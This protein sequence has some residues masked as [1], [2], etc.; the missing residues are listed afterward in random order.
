MNEVS[1]PHD[2]ILGL[3]QYSYVKECQGLIDA[4]LIHHLDNPVPVDPD[5]QFRDDLQEM[6]HRGVISRNEYQDLRRIDAVAYDLADDAT[7]AKYAVARVSIVASK[8]AIDNAARRCAIVQRAT[9]LPTDAFFITD[10]AGAASFADYAAAQ[11][12]TIVMRESKYA[13]EF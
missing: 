5:R 7:V 6:L 9:G 3:V 1:A 13:N 8:T 12:V 4:I 11:G 10:D 2:P